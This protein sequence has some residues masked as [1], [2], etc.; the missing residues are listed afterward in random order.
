M[1]AVRHVTGSP[2]LVDCQHTT[3]K[4]KENFDVLM[5]K[6]NASS[7]FMPSSLV[8]PGGTLSSSDYSSDWKPLLERVTKRRM[9][10]IAQDFHIKAGVRP[11]IISDFMGNRSDVLPA[12]I[13]FRICA[14]RETFEECGILLLT[15]W[16]QSFPKHCWYQV[17]ADTK[18]TYQRRVRDSADEFLTM[19]REL[20]VVPN[21]WL[22]HE[23]CNWL[24][25][26]TSK[27]K[28]PPQKPHR[29]DTL[30]YVCC[31]DCGQLPQVTVDKEEVVGHQVQFKYVL[32]ID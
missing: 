25:P 9:T 20:S 12:D 2:T 24:T 19:C 15:D 3:V 18:A 5:L 26:A 1:L 14:I 13:A 7:S 22:L 31:I 11:P 23:W 16:Q 17:D 6:R 29:F 4:S 28:E 8:F 27:V 32:Y 30:F 21:I 10:D